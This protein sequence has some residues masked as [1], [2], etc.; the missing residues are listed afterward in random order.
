MERVLE[1]ELMD[2]REQAEAYAAADFEEPNSLFVEKF[3]ELFGDEL[4]DARLLDLGCGPADITIRLVERH[5]E[6][7][8]DAVDGSEPMLQIARERLEGDPDVA[9]RL[10]LVH[11]RV[12]LT[13]PPGRDLYDA[14]ISNSLLHHLH[15]PL[16]FW[17]TV[18][19]LTRR[20]GPIL[21]MD[22]RRPD[23]E[24]EARALVDEYA[25]DEPEILREDFYNSLCAAFTPLEVRRQLGRVGL[26][27]LNIDLPTDRHLLV[28]GRR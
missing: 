6:W 15:E 24:E 8:I 10:R 22:L 2:G 23:S 28:S 21:V 4:D 14:A 7:E 11:A 5:P 16:D 18:A 19:D 13:E 26:G 20:N 27:R 12:P 25:A 17:Q 1:P 3:E 9:G